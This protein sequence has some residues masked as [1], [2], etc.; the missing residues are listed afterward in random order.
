MGKLMLKWPSRRFGEG[1]DR[2]AGARARVARPVLFERLDEPGRLQ[3]GETRDL[4][5]AGARIVTRQPLPPG[6]KISLEL[7]PEGWV[8][9]YDDTQIVEGRVVRTAPDGTGGTAMGV[10][11]RQATPTPNLL[12]R[13]IAP[14]PRPSHQLF[15]NLPPAHARQPIAKGAPT[16]WRKAAA[17]MLAT[18][19][20]FLIGLWSASQVVPVIKNLGP[21]HASTFAAT[22]DG[23]P[24][25]TTEPAAP[26][27]I[28]SL[29]G[30]L[31]PQSGVAKEGSFTANAHASVN[32]LSELAT[33][34]SLLTQAEAAL[35]A[36]ESNVSAEYF[37]SISANRRVS[38]VERFR[39]ILGQ[40]YAAA[41]LDHRGRALHLA[42]DAQAVAGV[43][44][45]WQQAAVALE[46]AL[47]QNLRASSDVAF[48]EWNK[49][50]P[51]ET[52]GSMPS[53][54]VGESARMVSAQDTIAPKQLQDPSQSKLQSDVATPLRLVVDRSDYVLRV[55][56]DGALVAAVPV[57]L[58]RDGRTPLGAFVIAN[59]LRDPDWY[60][61][62]RAVPHGD[63]ENPLGS[64][65][66]GLGNDDDA[67][68]Y[69]L[70]ATDNPTDLGAPV[71]AGCIRLRPSD[72]EALYRLCPVGTRVD[73]VE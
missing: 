63:P 8:A 36:G 41:R 42:R 47:Q 60:N 52:T 11:F 65:W 72:A 7:P 18:F 58:G 24:H 20:L 50:V 16:P 43:P 31:Q 54:G 61:R 44:D 67:T 32:E 30:E 71:S 9:R 21:A 15:L 35:A 26:V 3:R 51:F 27:S 4:S 70:H 53:N 13:P 37:A 64:R 29:A 57:G 28:A 73:I 69:G 59:K 19:M 17:L 48:E 23:P 46:A 45:V 25:E 66:M 49:L 33:S 2:R 68:S 62:G 12:R 38:P 22:T 34:A 10:E 6:A 56:R 40:A 39:A 14:T 1:S 5:A 55:L